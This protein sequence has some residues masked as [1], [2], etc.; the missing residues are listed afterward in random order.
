MVGRR[1]REKEIGA[2]GR[3]KWWRL[4]RKKGKISKDRERGQRR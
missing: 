3:K 4:L 1:Y 2:K